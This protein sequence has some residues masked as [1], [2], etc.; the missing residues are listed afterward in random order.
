MS[1][2]ALRPS[3]SDGAVNSLSIPSRTSS[4]HSRIVQP[5]P[6]TLKMTPVQP[7]RTLCYAYA[8]FGMSCDFGQYIDF[9]ACRKNR[10]TGQKHQ[11]LPAA[12]K[13]LTRRVQSIS[14]TSRKFLEAALALSKTMR[15]LG[16]FTL[17]CAYLPSLWP[18]I[19]RHPFLTT[20]KS[21]RR[22][23]SRLVLLITLLSSRIRLIPYTESRSA[24]GPERMIRGKKRSRN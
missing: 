21:L 19:S 3:T 7:T 14:S 22:K 11:P 8:V 5:L 10:T 20:S 23:T 9:Q 4:L 6:S 2:P 15:L 24:Y 13:S 1:P 17:P 16:L 18:L 12:E